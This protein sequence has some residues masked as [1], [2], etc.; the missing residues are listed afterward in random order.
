[1]TYSLRFLPEVE[2]D[3]IN[4]YYWYEAKANGLGED[5]LRM[6]YARASE[7]IWNPSIYPNVTK[8]FRRRLL[9]R[10]PYAV[11]FSVD[12]AQIVIFGLFHCARNPQAINAELRDR[13]E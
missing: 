1:M 13:V 11:Y 9:R 5:F 3:A 8:N 6:F 10:F 2:D 12:N 4:A 7:M